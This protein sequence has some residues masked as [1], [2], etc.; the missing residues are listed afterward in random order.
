MEIIKAPIYVKLTE[1]KRKTLR[2]AYTILN[3]LYKIIA[4]NN[5]EYVGD[6]C[7]NGYDRQEIALASNVL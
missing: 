3:D 7:G 6:T 5:C 4:D 1:E 2:D